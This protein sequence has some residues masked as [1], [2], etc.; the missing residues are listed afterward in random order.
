MRRSIISAVLGIAGSILA[1]YLGQGLGWYQFGQP[2]GFIGSVIGAMI[3]LLGYRM[4][5]G[6]KV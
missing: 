5:K 1:G 6:K 2:V 4:M 3:I